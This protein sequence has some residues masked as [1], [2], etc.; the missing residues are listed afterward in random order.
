M[1]NTTENDSI[2]GKNVSE[3]PKQNIPNMLQHTKKIAV[4][5]QKPYTKI[6]K[7]ELQKCKY[8]KNK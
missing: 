1:A 4:Q 3:K 5:I 6:V 2:G 8:T 7:K